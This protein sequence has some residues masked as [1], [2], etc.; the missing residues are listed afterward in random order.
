[1]IFYHVSLDLNSSSYF[2]PRIPVKRRP[3]ED[4]KTKRV[5]VSKTIEGCL[6][7]I[8]EVERMFIAGKEFQGLKVKIFTIDTC[9]LGIPDKAI[10]DSEY[11]YM[12]DKVRDA[13]LTEECWITVPFTVPEENISIKTIESVHEQYEDIYPYFIYLMAENEYGGDYQEAYFDYFNE[14]I[15]YNTVIEKV[16]FEEE[17]IK[18]IS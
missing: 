12:T 15:P 11:L 18:N 5:C 13:D 2:E 9:K 1:M 16:W 17:A 7:A 4:F 3:D 14:R 8:P 10:V 6:T